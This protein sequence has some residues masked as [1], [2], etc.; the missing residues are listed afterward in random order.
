M[1][2][3]QNHVEI[4]D[5]YIKLWGTI[6]LNLLK[7]IVVPIVLFSIM[8]GSCRERIS[9]TGLSRNGIAHRIYLLLYPYAGYILVGCTD[10][11]RYESPGFLKGTAAC[12]DLC[13]LE[14]FKCGN[15]AYQYER[16]R[17]NGRRQ[18]SN[19]F[20]SPTRCNY[21]HGWNRY[22]SGCLC[23]IHALILIFPK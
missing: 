15:P 6:F 22:L 12:N 5:G 21:K 8:S 20:R 19:F 2:K 16:L 9:H 4:A 11:G 7:F 17:E 3:N 13:I 18:R 23:H 14:L 1:R 10:N